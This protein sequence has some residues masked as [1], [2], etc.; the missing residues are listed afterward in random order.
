MLGTITP[1]LL[2]S[3]LFIPELKVRKKE[4]VLH[5]MVERAHRAGVVSHPGPVCD[6]L[7]VR[8]VLGATAPGRGIAVPGARSLL[9]NEARVVIARSRRGIEWGA[10]DGV[11]VQLVLL[12]LTP[13]E[14]PE[15]VHLDLIARMVAAARPQRSRQKL[16]EAPGF[17]TIASL[18][19]DAM[20]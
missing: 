14:Y 6:L 10:E 12:A 18:L 15:P 3:S 9:V 1:S 20:P 19:R 16:L 4:A 8:E 2:D 7:S 13:A 17:E 5:E 11:P